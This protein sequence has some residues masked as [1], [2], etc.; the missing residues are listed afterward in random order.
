V[1]GERAAHR[2]LDGITDGV[3]GRLK[4]KVHREK[5]SVSSASVAGLLGFAFYFA[6][7]GKVGTRVAPKAFERLRVRLTQLTAATGVSPW[8][9]ARG[10][11][12]LHRR[13]VRRLRHRGRAQTVRSDR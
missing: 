11:E 10:V 7:G 6:S 12:P 13:V 8:S 2:V 4:L 1:D 9:T 3:E 5:S